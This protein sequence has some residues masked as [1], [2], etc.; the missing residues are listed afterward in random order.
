MQGY[1]ITV[2][3]TNIRQ[4]KKEY[5]G[6]REDKVYEP[7]VE[8]EYLDEESGEAICPLCGDFAYPLS[9]LR[10]LHDHESEYHTPNERGDS[11]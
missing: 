7:P 1:R 8:L 4:A 5:C 6:W 9:Q 11:S 2:A 10:N 3:S